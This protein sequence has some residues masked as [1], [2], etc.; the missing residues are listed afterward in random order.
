MLVS[1]LDGLQA[2]HSS[3]LLSAVMDNL[4]VCIPP[5]VSLFLERNS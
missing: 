2:S 5:L 3:I 4:Q 1:R